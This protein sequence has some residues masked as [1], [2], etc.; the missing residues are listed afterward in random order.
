MGAGAALAGAIVGVVAIVLA[1]RRSPHAIIATIAALALATIPPTAGLLAFSS[2]VHE[3]DESTVGEGRGT[4]AHAAAVGHEIGT[5]KASWGATIALAPL[6]LGAIALVVARKRQVGGFIAFALSTL[7]VGAAWKASTQPGPVDPGSQRCNLMDARDLID[8]DRVAGCA[9]LAQSVASDFQWDPKK[10]PL[11]PEVRATVPDYD[12]VASKCVR[13]AFAEGRIDS[14]WEATQSPLLVDAK[15][16]NEINSDPDLHP[17]MFGC[18]PDSDLEF[19][20]YPTINVPPKRNEVRFLTAA[21]IET[22]PTDY[23]P[24]VLKRIVGRAPTRMRLRSCPE[25]APGNVTVML[26][27][28]ASGNVVSVTSVPTSSTEAGPAITTPAM[29]ECVSNA[30]KALTFPPPEGT[31]T[32]TFPIAFAALE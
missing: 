21:R 3:A 32:I 2:L 9:A 1:I 27:I 23:P 25:T 8:V 11:P 15:L 26:T 12:A 28:E 18:D 5:E 14:E 20:G 22:G 29:I 4:R 13:W 16:R 31:V 24:A 17:C 30:M 10:G 7:T 6:I 19:G